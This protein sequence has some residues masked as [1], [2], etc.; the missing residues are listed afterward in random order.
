[1][2]GAEVLIT[3]QS[4]AWNDQV[5]RRIVDVEEYDDD[6]VL[7]Q[8]DSP[9]SRP[10]TNDVDNFPV[11]VALLSRNIVINGG[12]LT[13]YRTPDLMQ[14]IS[15]VQFTNLQDVDLSRTVKTLYYLRIVLKLNFSLTTTDEYPFLCT[16]LFGSQFD[17]INHAICEHLFS[18]LRLQIPEAVV[19]Y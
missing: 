3:S 8:I 17:S 2:P 7:V 14:N 1:M 16:I 4:I 18:S 11:E 15:G 13:V 5:T 19:L 6:N 9:I 12:H 10:L